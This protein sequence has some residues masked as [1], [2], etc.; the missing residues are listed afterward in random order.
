M[1]IHR[2]KSLN[3]NAHVH[4]TVLTFELLGFVIN[5]LSERELKNRPDIE[6]RAGQLQREFYPSCMANA[7][8]RANSAKEDKNYC[9]M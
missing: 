4:Y 8:Q 6:Q 1:T 7:E 3:N 2:S 9:K 5:I